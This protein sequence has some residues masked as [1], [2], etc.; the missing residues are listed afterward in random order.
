MKASDLNF[1]LTSQNKRKKKKKIQ[2]SNW[3]WKCSTFH[4]LILGPHTAWAVNEAL[5]IQCFL[6][7]IMIVQKIEHGALWFVYWLCR[8]VI[9]LTCLQNRFFFFFYLSIS[10]VRG[11]QSMRFSLLLSKSCFLP[12][13]LQTRSPNVTV[14]IHRKESLQRFKWMFI[15][16]YG[17]PIWQLFE[18]LN[19]PCQRFFTHY[20]QTKSNKYSMQI[21]YIRTMNSK[22][23]ERAFVRFKRDLFI[24]TVIFFF[25]LEFCARTSFDRIWIK[26]KTILVAAKRKKN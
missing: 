23:L 17:S 14:N 15:L 25:R 16:L 10:F 26:N 3:P 5:W 9:R 8:T 13:Y 6:F 22:Y 2:T 1:I 4:L 7:W 12:H 21:L 11:M 18:L 19:K 20:F 24:L